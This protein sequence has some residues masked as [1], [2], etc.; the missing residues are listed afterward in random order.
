MLPNK[1]STL[2]ELIH[3]YVGVL[4]IKMLLKQC[5]VKS[6]CCFEEYAALHSETGRVPGGAARTSRHLPSSGAIWLFLA[7]S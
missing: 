2:P 4:L 5:S 3:F 6:Y 7:S 1:R